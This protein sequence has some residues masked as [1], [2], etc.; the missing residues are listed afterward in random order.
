[1]ATLKV[2]SIT[3]YFMPDYVR[4][5]TVR[6]GLAANPNV[7]LLVVKNTKRGA[8]RYLEVLR[9]LRRVKREHNPDVYWLN[10]RGYEILPFVLMIAGRKPVVYDE[11]VDPVLVVAEHRRG[12]KGVVKLLMG[13][14][15]IFGRVYYMI[16]R[17]ASLILTDTVANNEYSAQASGLPLSKYR[18]LTVGADESLFYPKKTTP[19]TP[20]RVFTYS[21]GNTPLH[22][23]PVI[24]EAAVLLKKR[25]DI[26]FMIA[27]TKGGTAE[28]VAE[29][30][31]RG[32]RFKHVDWI[33]FKELPNVVRASG[34][35][36]G[37]PFG[38][39]PQAMTVVTGKT[40]QFIA[41]EVPVIIGETLATSDFIH[42]QNAVVVPQANPAALA[43]AIAWLADHPKE[44]QAIA[45]AGR[46]LFEEKFSSRV[47]A[48][49]VDEI[50]GALPR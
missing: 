34:V 45:K 23:V 26:E 19:A 30:V 18:A 7:E 21:P 5:L 32:A 43:E 25:T 42:R 17:R 33:D 49:E 3:C 16:A 27:G 1:M 44:R 31:A 47:I 4:S 22:G 40:Y 6:A 10:F 2:V 50:L 29:A 20:F 39:T 13:L 36:L 24:M 37:G 14:W 41:C 46:K 28:L 11:L 15:P 48:R 12:K 38:G 9:E 8:G 35:A